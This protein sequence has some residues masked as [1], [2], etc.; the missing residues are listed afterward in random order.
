VSDLFAVAKVEPLLS[1]FVFEVERRTVEGQGTSFSRDVV[2]HKGAVGIVAQTSDGRVGLL[3]QYRA[4][5]DR[6][7]WEIPAGT[8][9]IPGESELIAA[10]RELLEEVG[11]SSNHWR[12][13]GSFMVS[14]GWTNQVMHLYKA[15][16]V[17]LSQASPEGPEENSMSVHWLTREDIRDLIR[18]SD[19]LDYSLSMGLALSFGTAF[20]D[21]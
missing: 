17:T 13:L 7:I 2:T 10:Q 5:F 3:R 19:S 12:K 11:G 6:E 1:S 15:E 20:F 8:L 14:P 16:Q 18:S 21:E 9:D 4:P